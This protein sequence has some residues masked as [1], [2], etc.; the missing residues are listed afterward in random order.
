MT[1]T[2]GSRITEHVEGMVGAAN[3][4]GVKL[5]SESEWRNFS[6]YTSEP[7]APPR[8]SARVRLGLDGSGFVRELQVLDAP[9][10][11]VD[12]EPRHERDREIRRMSALRSAAIYCGHRATVDE[13]IKSSDVLR[14][15]EA[16]LAWL[17]KGG[18][19]SA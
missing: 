4:K 15:A 8:R 2:N 14:I 5:T 16:W 19:Q 6:R 7:I 13:H 10:V 3:E 1:T 11:E 17:E 18:D 9:A 12:A